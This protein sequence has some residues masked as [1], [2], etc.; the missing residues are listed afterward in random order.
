MFRLITVFAFALSSVSCSGPDQTSKRTGAVPAAVPMNN[1]GAGAPVASSPPSGFGNPSNLVPIQQPASFD[2]GPAPMTATPGV[3]TIEPISIDNCTATNPAGLTAA[4]TQKLMAGGPPGSLRILYP[5]DGTVFPRG[6]LPPTLMWDGAA[7][8]QSVYLHMKAQRFEYKGCL[9]PTAE[10]QLVLPDDVWAKAGEKTMGNL[11]PFKIELSAMGTGAAAGPISATWTIAQATIKG[12]IYY[13]SYSSKLGAGGL[14]GG[15]GGGNGAVL[16]IPK[17][18]S[19]E[20]FINSQGCTAC[21][22]VSASGN[23]IVAYP[24]MTGA[25]ASYP[26]TPM[27][28]ANPNPLSNALI[29]ASFTAVSPE[30]SLFVTNAHQL[31]VGARPGAPGEIGQPDA[32]LFETD[33][34]AQVPNSGIPTTAMTPMFS[35]DG[36]QLAFTDYAISN[37]HGLAVMSFDVATKKAAGYRKVYTENDAG[38][39]PAWPFFLPDAKALVFARGNAPDFSGMGAG[40]NAFVTVADAAQ[41]DLYFVDLATGTSKMLAKAMGFASEQNIAAGQTYLPFGAAEEL[42]HNYYPTVAPVPAGGYFWVFF[43]SWRHYGNQG[44]QRQLWGAAI[45]V[46]ASGTYTSD[47][48]HPA[49]YL[50]GQEAA[51]GNHRAFAALDPCMKDGDTCTSGTDCCGG[52]C[53]VPEVTG[54]F[55]TEAVGSCNPKP[56]ATCS[57]TNDRCTTAAD[58]C[59]PE[60]NQQPNLCIAGFCAMVLAPQ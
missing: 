57:K 38:F 24:I 29:N 6:I 16:R 42:H 18:K 37:A 12:S 10:G 55:I 60:P 43:D 19:A 23:R 31:N 20:V 53:Y 49:F 25:G 47:P 44:L 11:D 21:H 8:V 7:A 2:A 26:V 32:L 36:L 15:L 54:E 30:G 17:G 48:S 27:S 9:K 22:S 46:S 59:P 51:T 14:L 40:I 41:S 3:K 56:P 34:G 1:A 28:A 58:C 5:Y 35:P 13:N 39:Y 52:F 33:T 50:T 45:D 4:N